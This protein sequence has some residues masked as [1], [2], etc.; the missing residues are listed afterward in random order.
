[1]KKYPF[2]FGTLVFAGCPYLAFAQVDSGTLLRQNQERLDNKFPRSQEILREF[3]PLAAP[4]TS[5]PNAER[6]LVREFRVIGNADLSD[7]EIQKI[8][9]PY[10]G[11]EL[12]IEELNAVAFELTKAFHAA[13]YFASTVYLPPHLISDGVIVLHVVSGYLQQ[14]GIKLDNESLVKSGVIMGYL[15]RYLKPDEVLTEADLERALLLIS[16]LHGVTAS[17][18]LL[19]GD[20]EGAG[21]LSVQA[22]P[23]KRISG[24]VAFDNF[25]SYATGTYRGSIG[26]GVNSFLGIGDN[27]D[28]Q[29]ANTGGETHFIYAGLG[30][31]LGPSGLHAEASVSYLD[32]ELIDRFDATRPTGSAFSLRGI[33]SYPIV[34]SR[35]TNLRA[36][37]DYAYSDFEDKALGAVFSKRKLNDVSFAVSGS[38]I[39]NALGGGVTTF[40]AS[41]TVG[42]VDLSGFLPN[43]VI[44]ALTVNTQGRFSKFNLGASRSQRLGGGWTAFLAV[45]SQIASNNLDTSQK[46]GLG[47]PFNIAGYPITE[48]NGDE[49]TYFQADLRHD[50]AEVPWGGAFQ[51]SGGYT[52]GRIKLL[53]DPLLGF[54]PL[55]SNSFTL[56]SL[57][58]GMHQSWESR[59]VI[60]GLLGI[61]LGNSENEDPV[62]GA[63][64]DFS[65]SDVRG[66]ISAAYRF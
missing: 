55:T 37:I 6:V 12:T 30:L 18:E 62:T 52:I 32:Y 19:P 27:L 11:R 45:N 61:Q 17:A 3:D 44:D 50:F 65:T 5:D 51:V 46:F 41:G 16:D 10:R 59:F 54:S 33:L 8:L 48:V 34:R 14:N 7:D 25:G 38:H 2:V 31:S 21:I 60:T 28:F 29:Y 56:Q 35:Q 66:W 53:N 63:D 4:S 23:S 49:G 22:E 39:D 13:G 43:Q 15:E 47:G 1:M 64:S 24:H 20:E 40:H 9:A 42:D 26:I 57:N 58:F 36:E